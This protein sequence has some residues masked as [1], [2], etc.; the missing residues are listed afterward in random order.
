VLTPANIESLAKNNGNSNHLKVNAHKTAIISLEA[1]F[2]ILHQRVQVAL[3]IKLHH[4]LERFV[5]ELQ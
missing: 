5:Q 1:I 4:I 3:Q 2:Q